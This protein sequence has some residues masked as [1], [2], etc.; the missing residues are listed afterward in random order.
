MDL[1]LDGK[2]ALVSG[3][4]SGIGAECARWLAREGVA[5][6]VAGRDRERCEAVAAEIGHEGG[7]AAAVTGDLST[8]AGAQHVALAALQT[9][10]RIDILVSN[11]GGAS[12][13]RGIDGWA[14]AAPADWVDAYS[15]NTVGTV[16]LIRQLAPHMVER[17]WGRLITMASAAAISPN[18]GMAHYAAAKAAIINLTLSASKAFSGSGVTANTI[19]PG[20]IRTPSLDEWLDDIARAQG[21][22]GDRDRSAAWAIANIVPQ[23]VTRMGSVEDIAAAVTYLASPLAGF[24]TGANFRIDGGRSPSMN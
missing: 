23:T 1:Q 12:H 20:M 13:G 22:P 11:A 7:T 16:R 5:V 18:P 10:G 17:R 24:I 15:S 2:C 14:G 4:S 3:G 19:S 21:W 6:V 9:R 8:D